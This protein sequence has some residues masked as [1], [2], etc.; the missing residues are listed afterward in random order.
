MFE[1]IDSG[2]GCAVMTASATSYAAWSISGYGGKR[3]LL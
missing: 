1:K 3:I 2:T